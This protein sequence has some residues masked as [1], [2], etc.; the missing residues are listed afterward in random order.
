MTVCGGGLEVSRSI[1]TREIVSKVRGMPHGFHALINSLEYDH[2]LL[3][4]ACLS[5]WPRLKG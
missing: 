4:F 1:G 2:V 3:A 5:R